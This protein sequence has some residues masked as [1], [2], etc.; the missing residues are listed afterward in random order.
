ME[1]TT[2]TTI[3]GA[4]CGLLGTL[5][6]GFGQRWLSNSHQLRSSEIEYL[7]TQLAELREDY[8]KLR[9]DYDSLRD[10]LAAARLE[11]A[12]ARREIAKMKQ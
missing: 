10:N 3:V 7:R 8:E 2:Q 9:V 12:L 6:G 5:A 1:D 4:I 11:L